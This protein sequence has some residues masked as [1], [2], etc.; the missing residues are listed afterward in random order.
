MPDLLA[1]LRDALSDAYDVDR[2]IG[3]G[4][5]AMVY[6]AEDLKHERQVAIK[7]LS[8]EFSSSVGR[9]RFLREIKMAARLTHP[10][11]LPLFDSG[12]ADDLLYFVM[13]YVEGTSLRERLQQEPQLPLEDCV[14]IARS[15]AGALDYAHRHDIMH[16]DIKPEN[17]ML[18]E[19]VPMVA[20]FGIG[21]ALS[22]AAG[23]N[24]TQV[25]LPI[26]T[27][28]Y[29]SPEQLAGDASVDGRSDVF[30]LGCVLFEMIAGRRPFQAETAEA[31]VAARFKDP[32]SL[33]DD[34]PGIPEY[35]E[36]AVRRALATDR[37]DRF[38]TAGDFA[39][40]LQAPAVANVAAPF[41]A[42]AV[43]QSPVRQ[44]PRT[45]IAVLPF[46]NLSTDLENEYLSDGITEEII[47]ALAQLK[48]LR[49]AARTSSFSFKHK[50]VDIAEV[51]EKLNVGTV[52]E[53]SVRKIGSR[54]RVTAQLI[55]VEDGYHIWSDRYDREVDDVFAIQDEIA[56]TIASRLQV[57]LTSDE[58][59]LVKPPTANIE[60]YDLYL[61]GRFLRNKRTEEG[62]TKAVGYFEQAIEHDSNFALAYSGLADAYLLLAAYLMRDPV[63][64]RAKARE[65]AD[66]AL[67]LDDSLAEAH[68]SRGQVMRWE[69]DWAG[70]EQAYQRAI[71]LNPNYATAHQWYATL[72]S[73]LG[74]HEEATREIRR[75][76]VLDPLSPGISITAATVHFFNGELDATY[77]YALRTLDIAP[78]FAPSYAWV[79]HLQALRGNKAECMAAVDELERLWAHRLG[80]MEVLRAN[81]LA[82]LGEF[83][84]ARAV[85]RESEQYDARDPGQLAIT[86]ARLS[87]LD[88]AFEW[89]EKS[90]E[91]DSWWVQNLKVHPGWEPI[92]DDPRFEAALKKMGL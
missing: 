69:R 58:P 18:H 33:D 52:L 79:A 43:M 16:R 44:R 87:E 35:L 67:S 36:H 72:L 88:A 71:A 31:E 70:E 27:P 15:V 7:V 19:D 38:E 66:K 83:D 10:N 29:M 37:R 21:K 12:E 56:S 26:G 28:A 45:S 11:I 65:A 80:D 81:N 89:L 32:P 20:D 90:V 62:L 34:R 39:R 6:L 73:I 84:E 57:T 1:D 41:A 22:A 23:D 46:S 82:V 91:S 25:G 60:A 2:E 92:R 5:M 49:V 63:E 48:A 78:D 42:F 75:A 64:A 40:A 47:N 55:S 61:K 74:R 24:I 54:L 8:P 53:G 3:R 14:T 86:Y 68:T 50:N 51:G 77:D 76:E 9:A 59:G 17:I 4:G 30:G 13:P 85:L